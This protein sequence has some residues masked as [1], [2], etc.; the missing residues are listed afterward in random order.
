MAK[1][2]PRRAAQVAP[3]R[4][5]D[6]NVDQLRAHPK[7][8]NQGDVGAIVESIHENGFYG[9]IVAQRSTGMI[10]AG[11]HRWRAAREA[12]LFRVPVMW[13]DCDDE[14]AL[15]VLLADNRTSELGVRD[16]AALHE[17][18]RSLIDTPSGL[19]GTG[20]D[21]DFLDELTHD[22]ERDM[23]DALSGLTD[24]APDEAAGD[25]PD[26]D[27]ADDIP[28]APQADQQAAEPASTSARKTR[29]ATHKG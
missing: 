19:D 9:V 5:E 8:P 11:E 10:L 23:A 27:E 1:N 18:L 24:P 13:L 21:A 17:L 20:Y 15:R 26:E 6:T 22:L 14:D 3:Q 12:G 7:N 29:R 25:A 4:Y 2:K 28:E 16:P